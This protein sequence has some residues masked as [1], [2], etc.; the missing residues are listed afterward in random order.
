MEK[1]C[2]R[3]VQAQVQVPRLAAVVPGP[4]SVLVAEAR[5]RV[6]RKQDALVAVKAGE[7][8]AREVKARNRAVIRPSPTNATRRAARAAPSSRR[9]APDLPAC[10][11][12]LTARGA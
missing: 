3:I 4:S 6:R 2:V 5:T 11:T 8:K 10:L 7:V 9:T 1:L 12:K